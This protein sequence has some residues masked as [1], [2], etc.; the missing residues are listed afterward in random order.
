MGVK[1]EDYKKINNV[2]IVDKE[3]YK[4][5]NELL[6]ELIKELLA[7]KLIKRG[8]YSGRYI[9]VNT[10]ALLK[11]GGG[12][13]DFNFNS[14]Y[15][16]EYSHPI[17]A[18]EFLCN[19]YGI[20]P[21]IDIDYT[22][23]E[24]ADR[25]FEFLELKTLYGWNGNGSYAVVEKYMNDTLIKVKYAYIPS[26]SFY[27]KWTY[28]ENGV[29]TEEIKANNSLTH[30]EEVKDKIFDIDKVEGFYNFIC[31]FRYKGMNDYDLT[32]RNAKTVVV[33]TDDFIE[34]YER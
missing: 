24:I 29:K 30:I 11:F 12:R 3:L 6:K 32:I 7:N 16:V 19:K 26:P 20:V 9:E 33:N 14:N 25:F 18:Y 28:Y 17:Y 13:I 21:A 8:D 1:I 2:E 10:N 31:S 5:V 23:T 4:N 15:K 22:K 27:S 34:K